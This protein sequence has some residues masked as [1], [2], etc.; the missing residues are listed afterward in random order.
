M[1]G[2]TLAMFDSPAAGRGWPDNGLLMTAESGGG[3]GLGF[4]FV[5]RSMLH[6]WSREPT[7]DGAMAWSPLRG[8]NLEPLLTV[9]IRRPPEHHSVTPNLVGFADGVGVIFAEIDGDVFT[10][11]VSS[12]RGKKVYRREDI[13]TIFPYTSFYTPRGGINF[14]PLP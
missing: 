13:H 9:L 8:I 12:R 11:E 6:L 1:S 14:D 4:A 2:H 5:R 3:G 7:G 10:I